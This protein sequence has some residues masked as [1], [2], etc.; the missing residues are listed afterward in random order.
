MGIGYITSSY[1][2]DCDWGMLLTQVICVW[3]FF[4]CLLPGNHAY[5][6]SSLLTENKY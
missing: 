1:D 3:W 2:Y 6:I 5:D 4:V